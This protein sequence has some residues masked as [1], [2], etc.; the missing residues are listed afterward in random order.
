MKTKTKKYQNKK[1]NRSGSFI[2]ALYSNAI[3]TILPLYSM[4]TQV[5]LGSYSFH[6]ITPLQIRFAYTL[7]HKSLVTKKIK[8]SFSNVFQP[9]IK[10]FFDKIITK[11]FALRAPP[12]PKSPERAQYTSIGR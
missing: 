2:L 9:V 6:I 7:P 11:T 12:F 4:H 5:I 10:F 3:Q 8:A 1:E